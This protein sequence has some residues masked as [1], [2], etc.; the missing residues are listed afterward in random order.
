M[1]KHQKIKIVKLAFKREGE[2]IIMKK[3]AIILLVI[4]LFIAGCAQDD[5]TPANNKDGQDIKSGSNLDK[6]DNKEDEK[7]KEDPDNNN[8]QTEYVF[9]TAGITIAVNG[10]LGPI[11][12]KL[13]E[14]L[15][16]FE[17]PSCAFQG[18]EKIYTYNSF[19][20]TSYELDGKDCVLAIVLLDDTVATKKGIH[21]YASLDDL[22][23]VYGDNYK[24][25]FGLYEYEEGISRLSFFVEDNKVTS[26]EYTLVTEE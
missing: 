13:G 3:L 20:I 21:L 12:E 26:I 18:M 22:I 2:S 19:E 8:N 1:Q 25:S 5:K 9:E 15:E 4:A 6:A 23:K 16:Y 11:L 14:P 17:A 7:D 24:E 10:E